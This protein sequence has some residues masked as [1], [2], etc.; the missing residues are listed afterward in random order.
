MSLLGF[1]KKEW[2]GEK[3]SGV[4]YL[5][6]FWKWA[7]LVSKVIKA[8]KIAKGE[9]MRKF[10]IGILFFVFM[11]GIA[12]GAEDWMVKLEQAKVYLDQ[13]QY[14]DAEQV[15]EELL[16]EHSGEWEVNY[17]MGLVKLSRGEN[18][19]AE[20]FLRTASQQAPE[21]L[22]I[23]LALALALVN[24]N[25]PELAK[26]ELDKVLAKDPDNAKALFLRG[27][28]SVQMNDCASADKDLNRAKQLDSAYK[29]Q[30][31]YY[32]GVCAA[33][34]GKSEEA[35]KQF[36]QAISAGAGTYWEDR[37]KQARAF[38]SEK[39]P[40]FVSADIFYQYD[41]NI[42]PVAEED[43]LPEQVSN[44][45]DSRT[46]VWLIG[47]YKPLI[48][49]AG[50]IA[51]E[52][53]FY[54][55]WHFEEEDLNLLIA[56]A[57]LNGFYNFKI[58]DIP[59]RVYGQYMYQYAGLGEDND[60]YS[61]THRANLAW[62]IAESKTLITELNYQYQYEVFDEPGEGEFD[63]DN[64]SHQVMLGQHFYVWDN[65]L[66]LSVFARYRA[67]LADGKN[68]D[69]NRWGAR[70]MARLV[71]WNKLSG[72]IYFDY[73]NRDYFDSTYDREDDV[74]SGSLEVQYQVWKYLAIFAGASYSD[75]QSNIENYDYEREIYSAGIRASY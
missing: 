30:A 52:A 48:R 20:K 71:E 40:F 27:V 1:Q 34:E 42:V 28:S 56:Q 3:S 23:R 39:K 16:K 46:V 37:A 51:L 64:S 73:D 6:G 38:V 19:S 66:D 2:I 45:D 67:V 49:D 68:Y 58:L 70:A 10:V 26:P 44:M 69:A 50:E 9:M 74:Y 33:Q 15:L 47:G 32:L 65:R 17:Y 53:R 72:W 18:D 14:S 22:H 60:Y 4:Y 35:K 24:Q 25:K 11:A 29:A 62:F 7:R 55:S 63:R 5:T 57:A 61:T 43:A 36:D 59:S 21:D 54:D 41:S 75:Y 12:I 8:D 13:K 31:S